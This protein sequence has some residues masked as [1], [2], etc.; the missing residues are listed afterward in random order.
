MPTSN[1]TQQPNDALDAGHDNTVNSDLSLKN[2]E[3]EDESP[4]TQS[5]NLAAGH[6]ILEEPTMLSPRRQSFTTTDGSDCTADSERAS[7]GAGFHLR[8]GGPKAREGQETPESRA[9]TDDMPAGNRSPAEGLPSLEEGK[10]KKGKEVSIATG[11]PEVID[12]QSII[13]QYRERLARDLERRELLARSPHLAHLETKRPSPIREEMS[14]SPTPGST[15]S[16]DLPTASTESNQTVRGGTTPS[17]T[18]GFAA[19]TPSYPFPRMA[20]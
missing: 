18:P 5:S 16:S 11:S 3:L 14:I 9:D 12:S 8:G 1:L 2:V 17:F 6:D 20:A 4:A 15:S 13:N 10:K 19:R 7:D